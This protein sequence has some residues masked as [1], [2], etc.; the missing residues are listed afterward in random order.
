MSMTLLLIIKD[1]I[2]LLHLDNTFYMVNNHSKV[3]KLKVT[4]FLLIEQHKQ[5]FLQL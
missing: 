2:N 3:F 1:L 5:V 4:H